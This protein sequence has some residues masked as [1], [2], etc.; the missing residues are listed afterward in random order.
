MKLSQIIAIVVAIAAIALLYN[1]PKVVINKTDKD[2]LGETQSSTNLPNGDVSK[3]T[4]QISANTLISIQRLRNSF[5]NASDN[6]KRCTFADSLA[7]LFISVQKIDSAAGYA[8]QLV[9]SNSDNNTRKTAG[10]IYFRLFS[11]ADEPTAANS[12]AAKAQAQ[13]SIVLDTDPDNA[14]VK[15][16]MA[17]TYVTSENPMKAIAL[18]REVIAK[19]PNDE[20]AIFNLGFLSI[21][22]GQHA[23]AVS[24]FEKLIQMNERNWKAHLYLGIAQQALGK[25]EEAAKAFEL[26]AKNTKDQNLKAQAEDLLGQ[27]N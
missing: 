22:S 20:N 15:N 19:N 14:E 13:F 21:Q 11:L 17:M 12:F 18:L 16:N 8:E 9:L 6:K 24:R 4:P 23:K 5:L 27:K 1:L 2:K 3:A 25:Q 7:D 26:V 10:N